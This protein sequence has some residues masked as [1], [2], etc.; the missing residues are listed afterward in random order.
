MTF[1][2]KPLFF[3]TLDHTIFINYDIGGSVIIH[4]TVVLIFNIRKVSVMNKL[5]VEMFAMPFLDQVSAYRLFYFNQ[6]GI[7]SCY[8][9]YYIGRGLPVLEIQCTF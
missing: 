1:H 4:V 2:S 5:W 6:K 3:M 7:V 8:Y 9:I